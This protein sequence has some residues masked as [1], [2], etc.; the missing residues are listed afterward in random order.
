[1]RRSKERRRW[2]NAGRIFACVWVG[3]VSATRPVPA[4]APL[5]DVTFTKDVLPVFRKYCIDCHSGPKPKGSVDLTTIAAVMK[6]G[7]NGR[8]ILKSGDPAAWRMPRPMEHPS[9]MGAGSFPDFPQFDR[10]TWQQAVEL[11]P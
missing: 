7:K 4:N 8:P 9:A 10:G 2:W 6:G 3:I 1:M 5:G 11:G